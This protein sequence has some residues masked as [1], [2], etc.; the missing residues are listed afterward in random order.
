MIA[1]YVFFC[2]NPIPSISELF[3][4]FLWFSAFDFFLENPK[5]QHP[6]VPRRSPVSDPGELNG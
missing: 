2:F 3:T 5:F 6:L 1:V 4:S